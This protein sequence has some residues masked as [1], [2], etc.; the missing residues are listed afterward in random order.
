[1]IDEEEFVDFVQKLDEKSTLSEYEVK[2]QFESHDNDGKK[3]LDKV[4]FAVCLHAILG[5]LKNDLANDENNNDDE[6][7]N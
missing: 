4:E 2:S 5:L 1:M 7:E 3:A 6:D